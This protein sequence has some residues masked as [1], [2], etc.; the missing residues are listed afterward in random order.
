VKTI[1]TD[2]AFIERALAGFTPAVPAGFDSRGIPIVIVP[3]SELFKRSEA[4]GAE[5]NRVCARFGIPEGKGTCGRNGDY[6]TVSYGR[7]KARVTLRL[8]HPLQTMRWVS[9]GGAA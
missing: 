1:Y 4:I 8:F 7:G 5:L 3:R 2:S 9:E 6:L